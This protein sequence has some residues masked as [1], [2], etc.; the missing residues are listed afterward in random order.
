[1]RLLLYDDWLSPRKENFLFGFLFFLQSHRG[2]ASDKAEEENGC[3]DRLQK[4][5]DGPDDENQRAVPC[6]EL[7]ILLLET[8]RVTK[9]AISNLNPSLFSF[10]FLLSA[11]FTF[12]YYFPCRQIK[13]SIKICFLKHNWGHDIFFATKYFNTF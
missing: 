12:L 1:L 3:R 13:I 4:N 8:I 5:D 9:P 2:N 6:L 7:S 11:V 10:Y